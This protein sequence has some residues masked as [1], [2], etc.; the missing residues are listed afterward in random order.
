MKEFMQSFKTRLFF[1]SLNVIERHRTGS[2]LCKPLPI[3]KKNSHYVLGICS[4]IGDI[5]YGIIYIYAHTHIVMVIVIYVPY[6]ASF[7]STSTSVRCMH[8]L[9]G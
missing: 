6:C 4:K 7:L 5:Y 9:S 8:F 3:K 2:V 1:F